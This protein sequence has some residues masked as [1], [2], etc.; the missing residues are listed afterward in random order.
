MRTAIVIGMGEIGCPICRMLCDAYG[1]HEV[2]GLDPAIEEFKERDQLKGRFRFMHVCYPQTPG[3]VDGMREYV[4]RF[5]P[6]IVIVHSTL[7]VGMTKLLNREL[8]MW[9]DEG[10]Q[11]HRVSVFYSPVRGNTRDGMLLGLKSYTKYLSGFPGRHND[12]SKAREHLR[13]AGFKVKDL[14]GDLEGRALEKAKLWDLAWYGLNIAFYQELERGCDLFECSV[15]REFIESTPVESEG[16]VPR[17]VFYGG[18][19]GGHCVI[20]GIEKILADADIPMLRAV[21][22]SNMKRFIELAGEKPSHHP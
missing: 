3:F 10:E 5:D 9:R 12:L 16:R 20:P 7:S 22:D 11:L 14:A 19:I 4:Q 18:H 6:E 15:V 21:I 8:G 13:E 17:I 2:R 1:S